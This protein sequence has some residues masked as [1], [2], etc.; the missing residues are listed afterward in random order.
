V[1]RLMLFALL[2]A[3]CGPTVPALHPVSGVVVRGGTPVKGG[4]LYF[5]PTGG[6]QRGLIHNA[7]VDP[8]GTFSATTEVYGATP[9]SR[10]GLPAGTYK[11]VYLPVS[12]GQKSGLDV[13]A[14]EVLTVPTSGPVTVTLPD[15]LPTGTGVKRDDTP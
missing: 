2:A 1:K 4:G 10:E 9:P 15:P 5:A 14:T 6:E 8:D 12:D 13:T 7:S 11:V 3:G